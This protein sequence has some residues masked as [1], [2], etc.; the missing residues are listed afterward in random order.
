V[1]ARLAEVGLTGRRYF[2]LAGAGQ[3]TPVSQQDLSR[4]LG[5]DP[6]TI[7]A[8]VD[9]LEAAGFLRRERSTVDRRRYDLHLTDAG[10]AA[11]GGAAPGV[12]GVEAEFFSML[13]PDELKGFTDTA[14]P[15]IPR[16]WP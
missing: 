8:I 16:F 7:V 1:E 3:G 13:P 10:K 5:I 2:V 4:M 9:E 12:G 6:T 14:L 11:L 15:V